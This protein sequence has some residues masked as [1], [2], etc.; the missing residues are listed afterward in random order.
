LDNGAVDVKHNIYATNVQ[1]GHAG[2]ILKLNAADITIGG[3]VTSTGAI[4]GE[5]HVSENAT[6]AGNIGTGNAINTI[7]FLGAK[8]LSVSGNILTNA[9]NGIDFNGQAGAKLILTGNASRTIE[10]GNN[11]AIV[12]GAND[13]V[14]SVIASDIAAGN[15]LKITGDIATDE[16]HRLGLIDVGA[17]DLILVPGSANGSH[18]KEVKAAKIT[19]GNTVNAKYTIGYTH[20]DNAGTFELGA[21]AQILKKGTDLGK[22]GTLYFNG[23]NATTIEDTVNLVAADV[24]LLI[25]G[26]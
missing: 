2:S 14:G 20:A 11:T 5:I 24:L 21:A 4:R 17:A 7:K 1:L 26:N 9:A 23:A 8:N 12:I 18:I 3:N 15:N 13:G 25:L 10:G 22:L 19:L 6:I 16:T